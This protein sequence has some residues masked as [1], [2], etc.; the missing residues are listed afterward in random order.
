MINI[1]LQKGSAQAVYINHEILALPI[2]PGLFGLKL[3]NRALARD[4]VFLLGIVFEDMPIDGKPYTTFNGEPGA[5]RPKSVLDHDYNHLKAFRRRYE[6][7]TSE[8]KE[9]LNGF[10]EYIDGKIDSLPLDNQMKLNIA[11]FLFTHETTL[12]FNIFLSNPKNIHKNI[13]TLES[14]WVGDFKNPRHFESLLP[15]NVRTQPEIRK[16]L[17]E[18]LVLLG[19]HGEEYLSKNSQSSP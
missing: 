7:L 3:Y 16:F 2:I 17:K 13:S 11:L 8:Q 6:K 18:G 10:F 14:H 5:Y 4:L 15:N 9:K 19:K 12:D 1:D